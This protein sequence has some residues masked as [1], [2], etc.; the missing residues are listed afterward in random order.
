M[1]YVSEYRLPKYR[2]FIGRDVLEFGSGQSTLCECACGRCFSKET[3]AGTLA[4]A[5]KMP[6]NVDLRLV[7]M[8]DPETNV[9]EARGRAGQ[10]N[11]RDHY[12]VIVIDGMYR[13]NMVDIACEYLAPGGIVY[14]SE[15]ATASGRSS[16][17]AI[18]AAWTFTATRR[19]SSC[20]IARRYISRGRRS[21]Y[22]PAPM[23]VIFKQGG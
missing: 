14:N 16:S 9:S 7:S 21:C 20:R 17:G 5:L 6:A 12:D 15:R 4:S 8:A 22:D 10:A 11:Q 1:V 13:P 19:G 18:S 23:H 2:S 3:P